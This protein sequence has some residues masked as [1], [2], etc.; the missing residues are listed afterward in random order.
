MTGTG[1]LA[2]WDKPA[3]PHPS[4]R[5][6]RAMWWHRLAFYALAGLLVAVLWR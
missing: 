1:P 4:D 2:P 5:E 6:R 3:Q